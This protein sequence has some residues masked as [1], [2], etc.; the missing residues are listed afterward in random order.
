MSACG[1]GGVLE[2]NAGRRA[3][4]PG[5][6]LSGMRGGPERGSPGIERFD[7]FQPPPHP[8]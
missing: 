4:W 3:A 7:R 1:E 8:S 5:L 2:L 6:H